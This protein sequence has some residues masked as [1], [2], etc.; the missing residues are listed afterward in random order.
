MELILQPLRSLLRLAEIGSD[1]TTLSAFSPAMMSADLPQYFSPKRKR[2]PSDSDYYSPSASPASTVSVVSLPEARLRE[3][4][5]LERHS[6]RAA[7]AGR[8]GELAIRGDRFPGPALLHRDFHPEPTPQTSQER[9]APASYFRTENMPEPLSTHSG[10]LHEVQRPQPPPEASMPGSADRT[11]AA[12][13]LSPSEKSPAPSPR[14]QDTTVSPKNRKK[15]LSPPLA[16]ASSEVSLTWHDDEITG[17]NPTDPTDDGYGINGVG[18]KPTA[19]MAWARS[20]KRQKQVAEWK[21]REARDAREKRR[22]RRTEDIALERIH[23]VHQGAI[24][25]RVKFDV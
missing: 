14:K 20:Q 19:A 5:E 4:L 15:R 7:V 13:T 23:G 2:E 22:A 25:K 24:Q 8:F 1:A 16:D 12:S 9:C 11:S 3:E 6:P 18:F 17:H 21:A 10:G